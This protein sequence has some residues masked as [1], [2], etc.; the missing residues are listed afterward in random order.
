MLHS[1]EQV[2]NKDQVKIAINSFSK[3]S[4][5]EITRKRTRESIEHVLC[6]SCSA[7]NGRGIL[8]RWKTVCFE[9]LH[10]IAPVHHAYDSDRFLVYALAAVSETLKSEESHPLAEVEIVS[11]KLE[12]P[13]S[14]LLDSEE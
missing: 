1:L 11:S 3:L 12:K 6:R 10:E 14:K 8:K 2:L 9:I 4:L 7:C 5:A 13:Q